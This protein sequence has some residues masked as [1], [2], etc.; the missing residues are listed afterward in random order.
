MFNISRSRSWSIM[1]LEGDNPSGCASCLDWLV[2]SGSLIPFLDVTWSGDCRVAINCFILYESIWRFVWSALRNFT[3][4]D[5]N[6]TDFPCNLNPLIKRSRPPC[7]IK[8]PPGIS[9]VRVYHPCRW[10]CELLDCWDTD[11]GF[12]TLVN[13]QGAQ[14]SPKGRQVNWWWTSST[15]NWRYTSGVLDG[16]GLWNTHISGP[17]WPTNQSR[18]SPVKC[19]SP[20]FWS[21]EAVPMCSEP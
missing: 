17:A 2:D 18:L 10:S 16:P 8:L 6:S 11:T 19:R 1:N 12:R 4:W 3:C 9:P 13:V 15:V 20:P 21:A 14:D 5:A 7:D